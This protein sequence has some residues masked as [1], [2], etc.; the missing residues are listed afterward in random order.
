VS[1]CGEFNGWSPEAAPMECKEGGRWETTLVLRPGRYQYKFVA[2]GRWIPDPL[3][4]EN[5]SN[6][7]G[8]LNS[9][10]DVAG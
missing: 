8:S 1:L 6:P 4:H 5:I 7:L 9:V 2:D 3:A 10:L